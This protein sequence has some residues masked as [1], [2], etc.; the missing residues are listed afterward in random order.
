MLYSP[1][2]TLA[3][4]ASRFNQKVTHDM[5]TSIAQGM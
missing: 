5:A 3:A 1:N 2:E 4:E